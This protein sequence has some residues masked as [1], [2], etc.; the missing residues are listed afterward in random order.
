VWIITAWQHITP[1]VTV[2][3]FKKCCVS[4]GVDGIGIDMLRNGSE[5]DLNVRSVRKMKAL[6]VKMETVTLI[7]KSR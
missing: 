5:E 3:G 6:T 2:K 7:G 1:E 4:S